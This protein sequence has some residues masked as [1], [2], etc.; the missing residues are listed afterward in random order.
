MGNL[1]KIWFHV[2]GEFKSELAY[3]YMWFI[4]NNEPEFIAPKNCNNI[5][6][7]V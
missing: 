1:I 2:Y 4:N 5:F 3:S 6:V 7:F